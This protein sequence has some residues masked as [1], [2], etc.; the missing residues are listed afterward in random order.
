M[1]VLVHAEKFGLPVF[2][3]HEIQKDIKV[4]EI[5]EV[6]YEDVRLIIKTL[7]KT[8]MAGTPVYFCTVLG[9]KNIIPT[10]LLAVDRLGKSLNKSEKEYYDLFL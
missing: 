2:F 6:I 3:P 8:E 7:W 5:Y 1:T 4:E 10:A 9:D